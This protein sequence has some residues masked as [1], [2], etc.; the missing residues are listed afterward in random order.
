MIDKWLLDKQNKASS[1]VAVDLFR[2]FAGCANFEEVLG[3]GDPGRWV[4]EWRDHL[5]G[6]VNRMDGSRG[7]APGS[8]ITYVS[9]VRSFYRHFG[10]D[11]GVVPRVRHRVSKPHKVLT[12][13][14]FGLMLKHGDIRDKAVMWCLYSTG[15]RASSLLF[16][17]VGRV[18]FRGEVPV[19]LDFRGE[20]TKY[21]VAYRAFLCEGALDALRNYVRWRRRQGE[22]VS[23]RSPLFINK[24]GERLSYQASKDALEAVQGKAGIVVHENERFAH[25]SF[26][27]AF[28]RNLQIVGVNQF[29]IEKLMGHSTENT[30]TGRYSIGVT[31]EDLRNAYM[32]AN[33]SMNIDEGIVQ[34]LEEKVE[35]TERI[36]GAEIVKIKM[37]Q[38][39]DVEL[40]KLRMEAMENQIRLLSEYIKKIETE[41]EK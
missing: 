6:R 37:E 24:Y 25:H 26:R 30:T 28:Q 18:D 1:R 8:V 23:L 13:D 20:E 12:E 4:R 9:H 21:N 19:A 41:V 14:E 11:V 5:L 40:M 10:V 33:W 3:V 2:V 31:R 22:D 35:A 39:E 36:L 29:M 17:D 16:L 7:L 32:K 38:D 34:E 15:A 27:A